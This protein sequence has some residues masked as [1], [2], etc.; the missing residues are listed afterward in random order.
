MSFNI[1]TQNKP[2]WFL[3]YASPKSGLEKKLIEEA[4]MILTH[5]PMYCGSIIQDLKDF[6]KSYAKTHKSRATHVGSIAIDIEETDIVVW[7][8]RFSEKTQL[9]TNVEVLRISKTL[10]QSFNHYK[11]Q[12]THES[13][14]KK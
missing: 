6:L 9:T 10:A 2:N 7:N 14:T 4:K 11:N 8:N 5:N 3:S 13:Q 12:T 1:V